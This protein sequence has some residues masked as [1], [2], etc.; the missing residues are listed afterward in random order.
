MEC[1]VS[2]ICLAYNHEEYIEKTLKAFVNQKTDF[3]VKYIIHDDAST[4]RTA[5]IIQRYANEYPNLIYPIIEKT[6]QYAI[7]KAGGEDFTDAIIKK[8]NS[9]YIAFC[10]GDDYW[11][12]E[13][14][15]KIQVDFLKRHEDYSLVL[16]NGYYLDNISGKLTAMDPYEE[17]GEL[18]VRQV[19]SE[20]D[21]IPPTASMVF[22]SDIA[23]KKPKDVFRAPVG[24]RPLRMYLAT[25]G[26]V[27][28]FNKKMCAYRINNS[29][30]FSGKLNNYYDSKKLADSMHDFYMRFDRYTNY[31]YHK[32]V[33][34]LDSKEYFAHYNRFNK[35]KEIRSNLYYKEK[36]NLSRKILIE[37][38]CFLPKSMS[39][40]VKRIIKRR[41]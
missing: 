32:E 12:D 26:K 6:N 34:L 28:Y 18:T 14:K 23:K 39:D 3:D 17:E 33:A 9:P 2:V 40:R 27:Y 21:V 10:E 22:R 8:I 15:L 16:H 31:N 35:I 29:N 24:D 25:K 19:L 4:D 36:I 20:R 37:M 13:N 41:K 11:I 1:L 38:K 5:E 30:S 7:F